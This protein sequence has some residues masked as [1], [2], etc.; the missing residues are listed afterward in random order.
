MTYKYVSCE[1]F[2]G[3]IPESVNARRYE[4]ALSAVEQAVSL[5]CKLNEELYSSV[6]HIGCTDECIPVQDTD[7]LQLDC[8]KCARNIKGRLESIYQDIRSIM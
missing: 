1:L 7:Y 8:C 2:K 3:F 5:L 4:E 6:I